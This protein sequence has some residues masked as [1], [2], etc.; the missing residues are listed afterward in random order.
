LSVSEASLPL[1]GT[2]AS[3]AARWTAE[4]T[5][6]HLRY[7]LEIVEAIGLC[8]WAERARLDGVS[9]VRVLLQA[10]T[11]VDATLDAIDA[12]T[13]DSQA[14]VA[15]LI[16]PRLTLGSVEFARFVAGVQHA[17]VPRHPLGS[18]PF[19][20]AAF[21]PEVALDA[22]GADRLVPFLRRT[23]D[24]TIQLLRSSV[25]ERV[26]SGRPQGTQFFDARMLESAAPQAQQRLCDQIAHANLAIVDR[27]GVAEL[28]RRFDAIS[29]D[30]ERSYRGLDGTL[31][32]DL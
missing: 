12:L 21:H 29:D 14:E 17:D 30:R 27:L 11:R 8:P 25:L 4:A 2:P 31:I 15:F 6:L 9:R 5:R 1:E 22:S 3:V 24:P 20:F 26:R 18:L 7:Q 19:M 32:E 13:S 28:T 16:Y 10:D 23:P